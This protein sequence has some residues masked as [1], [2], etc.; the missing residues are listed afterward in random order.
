MVV[1]IALAASL[2]TFPGGSTGDLVESVHEA[3]NR[4]VFITQ[5]FVQPVKKF[6][7]DTKSYDDLAFDIRMGAKVHVVPGSDLV[8]EDTMLPPIRM[9]S[10]GVAQGVMPKWESLSP[11]NIAKGLVTFQTSGDE[12]LDPVYLDRAPFSK[13]VIVNWMLGKYGVAVNVEKMPEKAFLTCIAQSVGGKLVEDKENYHLDLDPEAFRTRV[14]DLLAARTPSDGPKPDAATQEK[15]NRIL[16]LAAI[17]R[18]ADAD[19]L[20]KAFKEPGSAAEFS[21]NSSS[22]LA[23]DIAQVLTETGQARPRGRML[24]AKIGNG[25]AFLDARTEMVVTLKAD[26]TARIAIT[27]VD[28]RD[29]PRTFE[30]TV[31]P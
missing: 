17:I 5:A 14:L 26:F 9:P 13:P 15:E 19:T 24:E 22:A 21:A 18:D 31:N 29:R 28:N 12:R 7:F 6:D 8:F 30:L 25:L 2:V 23:S 20:L 1:T 3:T 16:L 10:L 27:A 4:N 11:E